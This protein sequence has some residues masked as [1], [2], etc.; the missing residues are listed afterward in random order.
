MNHE[1]A[2]AEEAAEEVI[3]EPSSSKNNARARVSEDLSDHENE[4]SPLIGDAHALRRHTHKRGISYQRAINEPW[5]GAHGTGPLPWYK[6]P[7]VYWLLPAFFPFCIAF[8]GIIVPKTYL[9]QDLICRDLLSDRAISDP[10]YVFTPIIPGASNPQCDDDNQVQ[11]RTAM[12]NLITNVISGVLSA[13]VAPHLGA[14]S[15]RIGRKPVIV[16]ASFGGFI[17]ELITIYVGNHAESMSVNWLLVG[18]TADGLCGSFTTAMALCFAYASD[19]TPPDRRNIAFGHFHATLFAGIAIGPIFAGALIKATGNILAPFYVALGCHV[20]FLTFTTFVVPESL[21]KERQLIAKER[22]QDENSGRTFSR[23]NLNIFAPLSI[24]WPTGPGS[25]RALRRNLVVLAA[26]D[27]MMFG[28]AMGT[29]QIVLIYA[30]KRFHWDALMSSGYLSVTNITRV[31]GLAIV[32]PLIT[33]LVRGRASQQTQGHYGCD[34]L[35][36]GVIRVSVLFDLLGYIG[37]AFTPSGGIMIASGMIASL[38]GVGPPVLQSSMTK[39]I[40]ADRTGQILGASG[41]LHALARVVA[42]IVFNLIYS[43]T[44]ATFAGFV[45]LCLG[46]IFVIVFTIS[47]FIKPGV[48]LDEA[49]QEFGND[50]ATEPLI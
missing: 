38:G 40:P 35:D 4:Q 34:R 49:P 14:L 39:H 32:L 20:F 1:D 25:S 13:L 30:R 17:G 43:R 46:S 37:F 10:N 26:I 2:W 8:G 5:T 16:C 44:V 28:V 21:S 22:H 6:K 12:F 48:Y 15:D 36:L 23:K 3:G 27:T 50:E 9:I 33:R 29:M 47:W 19:C 7:S 11:S 42:P 24:L 31:T 18:Y 45:F 41:L